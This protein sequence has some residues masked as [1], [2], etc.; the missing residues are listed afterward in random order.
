VKVTWQDVN[1][2]EQPGLYPIGEVWVQVQ[3]K[4]IAVWRQHPSAVF[5]C[6]AYR[7]SGRT[8]YAL[9]SWSVDND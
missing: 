5:T 4:H 7:S 9:G 2:T 1:E 6:A 3:S 8:R